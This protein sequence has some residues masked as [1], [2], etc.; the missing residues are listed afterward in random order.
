MINISYNYIS[1]GPGKVVTN[2]ILG[3]E[4]SGVEFKTNQSPLPEDKLLILQE[5]QLLYQNINNEKV[6]GPNICTLPIDNQYVMNQNYK[7]MIVP[8]EWVKQ[9]YMRWLPEEKLFIWAAGI[10]TDLFYDMSQK[11]KDIDCLIYFKRRDE[12]ELKSV[13][14]LLTE[15]N[16]TFDIVR[17]GGYLEKDLIALLERSRYCIVV[18]KCESQGIAIQE[19]MSSNTPLLVWDTIVWDDRGDEF[20]IDATSVPYWDDICGVKV[21]NFEELK[22]KFLFFISDLKKYK[23]RDFILENLTLDKSAKKIIEIL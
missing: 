8:C 19:I 17:Y 11:D 6:I 10:D 15:H 5:T 13:I 14:S 1:N 4:K 23:P 12:S 3:L 18:D 2:L 21:S 20:K 16:Q 9:L 7:K 22:N